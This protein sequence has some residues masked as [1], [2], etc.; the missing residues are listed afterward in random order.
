VSVPPVVPRIQYH[1]RNLFRLV[2]GL[3]GIGVERI[4]RRG[5]LIIASNHVSDF[6]PPMLGSLVP[7]EVRFMAK[8]ELFGGALGSFVF[9]KIGAFPV[10]RRSIDTKA[11]RSALDFLAAGY[12]VVVFPEGTR[13][14]PERMLPAKPGVGLLVLRT[15]APVLPCYVRGTDA[16][17]KAML[18]I[19]L[20]RVRFGELMDSKALA[21][22]GDPRKIAREI[23]AAVGRIAE[24]MGVRLKQANN[25]T[26]AGDGSTGARQND[27]EGSR[28]G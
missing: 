3:K 11:V 19:R 1:A 21:S 26:S 5:P 4:P 27:G 18:R 13:G 15:G 9:P 25:L 10:H 6:D 23:M 2:Y 7:R 17:F 16:P 28:S 14:R 20:M 8:S 22:L 12:A 24:R